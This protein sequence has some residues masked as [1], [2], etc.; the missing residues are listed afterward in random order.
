[1]TPLLSIDVL[2]FCSTH[3]ENKLAGILLRLGFG[4]KNSL[5]DCRS[6]FAQSLSFET[7]AAA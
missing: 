7:E 5:A 2:F 4:H 3:C 6:D 1:L